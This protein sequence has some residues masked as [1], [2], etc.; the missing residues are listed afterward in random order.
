M[1]YG[2]GDIILQGSLITIELALLSVMVSIVLGLVGASAK[3]FG[4]RWMSYLH[5]LDPWHSRF[6]VNAAHFLWL[7]NIT[8]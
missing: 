1:L 3:I 8:E 7:A 4:S 6:S 5:N 2:Y